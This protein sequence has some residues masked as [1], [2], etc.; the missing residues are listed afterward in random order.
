MNHPLESPSVVEHVLVDVFGL[1]QPQESSLLLQPHLLD[2]ALEIFSLHQIRN[3]VV[4]IIV[5]RVLLFL[6][7]TVFTAAFRFLQGLVRFGESA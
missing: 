5:I 4:V 7:S 2:L 6:L 3:L 1:T